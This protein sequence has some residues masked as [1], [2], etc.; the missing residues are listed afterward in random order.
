VP[1]TPYCSISTVIVFG[2]VIVGG[3]IESVKGDAVRRQPSHVA[4]REGVADHTTAWCSAD[5]R[6]TGRKGCEGFDKGTVPLRALV[7][8]SVWATH[9]KVSVLQMV[10]LRDDAVRRRY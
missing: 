8:K 5:V 3:Q 1:F 6:H 10:M 7:G 9:Y 4:V 2:G